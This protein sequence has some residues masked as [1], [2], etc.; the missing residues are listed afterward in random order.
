MKTT[1]SDKSEI[2]MVLMK[3]F[4]LILMT[5]SLKVQISAMFFSLVCITIIII[6]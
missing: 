2:K 5:Q 3:I 6:M 4:A 1:L